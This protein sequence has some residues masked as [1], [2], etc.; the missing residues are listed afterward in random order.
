LLPNKRHIRGI[1]PTA[2]VDVVSE[3]CLVDRLQSFQ[4]VLL[5]PNPDRFTALRSVTYVGVGMI[6]DGGK[7][8]YTGSFAYLAAS[9]NKG[10]TRS[11][12]KFILYKLAENP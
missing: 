5:Y 1:D 3:I 10:V 9:Q 12:G 2:V 4:F 7:V 6:E 8:D 11:T